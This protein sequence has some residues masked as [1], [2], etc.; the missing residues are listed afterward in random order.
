[1]TTVEFYNNKSTE[2]IARYDNANMSLLH[3]LLLKYIPQK[4]SVL[5]I[6]FGS[7]RDL[8]FLQDNC[9][10]IW[11]VDTSSKFVENAKQRFSNIKEQFFEASVPFSKEQLKLNKQFDTVVAIAMW[12]HL[13]YNEYEDAVES[14]VSVAKTT[15]TIIISYSKGIRI[16]DE[17]YFENVDLEYITQLFNNKGFRLIE[18]IKN[19]DSLD[20]DNLTWITVVYKHD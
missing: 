18:T 14:I 19:E 2:L 6:G 8:H 5:D 9:C 4:S 11:G 13:K 20:R 7:G 15:S 17:R 1:M 3:K 12:M 16:D 10:D